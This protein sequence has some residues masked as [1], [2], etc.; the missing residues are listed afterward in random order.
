MAQFLDAFAERAICDCPTFPYFLD[1]FVLANEVTAVLDEVCENFERLRAEVNNLTRLCNT[2][3]GEIERKAVE[4]I[5]YY[6]V[7]FIKSRHCG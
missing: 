1:Q 5:Y 3:S 2:A 6:P 7:V 4:E